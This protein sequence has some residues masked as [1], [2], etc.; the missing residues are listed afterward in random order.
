MERQL[1]E[2]GVLTDGTGDHNSRADEILFHLL[3]QPSSSRAAMQALLELGG[4]PPEG[5]PRLAVVVD[6][7]DGDEPLNWRGSTCAR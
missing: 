5:T 4:P 7:D 1:S 3:E 6:D 2:E